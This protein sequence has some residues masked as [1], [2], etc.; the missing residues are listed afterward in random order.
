MEHTTCLLCGSGDAYPEIE[1]GA[2]MFTGS[3]EKF[4]FVRCAS[5]GLVYLNPRIEP[6]ELGTY[7]P[8]YYLP[9]RG[10][11]AWGRF[12]PIAEKGLRIT[13]RRR[14]RVAS[15]GLRRV[16]REV[17][18]SDSTMSEASRSEQHLLDVGCGKPS[19]LAT[20]RDRRPGLRLTGIDFVSSGWQDTPEKWH[21]LNLIE[22]EPTHFEPEA[23]AEPDVITM[24]HYLEHDYAPKQTLSRMREISHPRT[25]LIVE[26]PDYNSL[27]RLIYGPNWQG[28]HAPRH[29][30]IYT[31]QTLTGML[32]SAGWEVV[33]HTTAGTLDIYALW[34]MSAMEKR[35][36]D[37]SAS[38]EPRFIRFMI[39]RVL[40]APLRPLAAVAPLGV[41]LVEARPGT[42]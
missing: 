39:G 15:R 11:E 37:W 18:R 41:Q 10:G 8:S 20:L 38:M 22:S 14:S 26:V 2:Q 25:R 5:C 6:E 16:G 17:R 21:G 31:R 19:F 40:T 9:Y 33:S 23:G 36:I 1:T 28:F 13:D 24:W 30:A 4:Q 12:A 32:R 29:T 27:P 3:Q 7:Y 34:W 35:G 42:A